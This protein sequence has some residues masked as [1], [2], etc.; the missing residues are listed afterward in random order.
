MRLKRLETNGFGCL[1]GSYEFG[2]TPSVLIVENNEKGKSTLVAGILA[3][4]YGLDDHGSK[5]IPEKE[6]FRPVK[7][8]K[9]DVA[10]WVEVDGKE[11]RIARD[12]DSG[13]VRVWNEKT[14]RDVTTRFRREDGQPAVGENLLRL[15]RDGF[16]KTS[17]IRQNEIQGLV[18]TADMTEKIEAMIDTLSGDATAR[19]ALTLLAE[20][21]SH[22]RN[23]TVDD[24]ISRLSGTLNRYRAEWDKLQKERSLLDEKAIA[25]LELE[26]R[27]HHLE[28]SLGRIR[29][30]KL[31]SQ[32][33][34]LEE[35]LSHFEE[36]REH[37]ENLTTELDSLKEAASLPPYHE[38]EVA[39]AIEA[40]AALDQQIHWLAEK[41]T[42]IDRRIEKGREQVSRQFG[43]LSSLAPEDHAEIISLTESLRDDLSALSEI[44]RASRTEKRR[45]L[46]EGYSFQDYPDFRR[47]IG[48]LTT[49]ERAGALRYHESSGIKKNQIRS[50]KKDVRMHEQKAEGIERSLERG[51]RSRTRTVLLGCV[52][53]LMAAMIPVFHD[54]PYGEMA[55]N[56]PID[57]DWVLAQ[58][59]L[60]TLGC[61]AVLGGVI[62]GWRS[63]RTKM[64][65]LEQTLRHLEAL[66]KKLEG[67][68]K[69]LDGERATIEQL[70]LRT[71]FRSPDELCEKVEQFERLEER[72]VHLRSLASRL[73]GLKTRMARNR[74]KLVHHMKNAG[75]KVDSLSWDKMDRFCKRVQAFRKIESESQKAQE[76]RKALARTRA[77]LKG[78]RKHKN[79]EVASMF[80]TCQISWEGGGPKALRAF[81]ERLQKFHRAARI[82]EELI[83]EMR[84]NQPSEEVYQ[85][86]FT[87]L[88]RVKASL[89]GMAERYGDSKGG[90][91]RPGETGSEEDTEGETRAELER[92]SQERESLGNEVTHF[93][94]RYPTDSMGLQDDLSRAQMALERAKRFDEATKL[95]IR[96]L[97]RI[98]KELHGRCANFMNKRANSMLSRLAPTCESIEIK[99]DLSFSMDHTGLGAALDQKHV[100]GLLSVGTRD[101]I[102]LVL[103]LA[104]SQYLSISGICLPFIL[105]DSLIT[106]DDDRFVGTMNFVVRELSKKHQVI[107][108]TCHEKRH[109]WWLDHIPKSS[110]ARVYLSKLGTGPSTR[111]NQDFGVK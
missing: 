93:L 89:K 9:F 11:Y 7:W 28:D 59:T 24:E 70:A 41:L 94:T 19:Q 12:F 96:H 47:R 107:M 6:R 13:S 84:S 90:D 82:R 106:S 74:S 97:Q 109:R 102:Y 81:R 53:G 69:Q 71:G 36:N 108:L 50:R 78:E 1:K 44:R 4:L 101:Q 52:F 91:R 5:D 40:L 65:S 29:Y 92:I 2:S 80:R 68:E 10:L 35:R 99:P 48:S 42:A 30:D 72:T 111:S 20:A 14:G 32:Q 51:R 26:H 55:N 43:S 15:S 98:Q 62:R 110:R 63:R 73:H 45:I 76:K 75:E 95:A 46:Q 34:A 49:E 100:D 86:A 18:E 103:R 83:P 58:A 64:D 37:F 54:G 61:L 38:K 17:L 8:N 104:I 23:H 27:Q 85:S 21:R 105:D 16:L 57:I 33:R 77:Q 31:L 67:M 88:E 3:A 66:V 22:C 87:T 56:L 79:E 25:L 39:A 60:G